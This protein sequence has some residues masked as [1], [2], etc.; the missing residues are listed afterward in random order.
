MGGAQKK[1]AGSRFLVRVPVRGVYIRMLLAF[2]R[3]SDPNS[4]YSSLAWSAPQLELPATPGQAHLPQ[5]GRRE[6]SRS[7][8][9]GDAYKKY[10]VTRLDKNTLV[11]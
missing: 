11:L 2:G 6:D 3:E 8:C 4:N 10:F 1:T 7:Q 5:C 9:V